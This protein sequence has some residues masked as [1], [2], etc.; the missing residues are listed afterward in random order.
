MFQRLLAFVNQEIAYSF[1]KHAKHISDARAA[2]ML[3][4]SLLQRAG[5]QTQGAVKEMSRPALSPLVNTSEVGRNELCPC[6]S[7]KKFKQCHGG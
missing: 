4:Q 6:G 2:A 7:G 5:M 1:F 3:G